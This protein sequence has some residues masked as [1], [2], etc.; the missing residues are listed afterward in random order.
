MVYSGERLTIEGVLM[1]RSRSLR[2]IASVAAVVLLMPGCD[3]ND[4]AVDT[5]LAATITTATPTTTS[6]PST[7]TAAVPLEELGPFEVT[8][9]VVSHETTRDISVWAPDADGSWPIVYLIPAAGIGQDLAEM[10][11]RLA[12]GGTVVFAPD[13]RF[14]DSPLAQE[15]DLECGYRYTRTIAHEYGGDLDQPVTVVGDSNGASL[16][17]FGGLSEATYGPGGSY[18]VCFAGAPR[19]DLIVPIAGC[20]YEYQGN[21]F[22]EPFV[23]ALVD[24]TDVKNLDADLVLVVGEDDPTCQP[25]QSEDA[26]E[27]LQAAGYN[28]RV[29]VVP[30]GDHGNMV[31]WRVVDGEWMT[32]PNDPIGKQVIQIILDAIDAAQ[33]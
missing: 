23:E 32:A 10:A 20:H 24:S 18:D 29:V 6:A 31:F 12:S 21:K 5:T 28:A 16:A 4:A 14:G 11:T 9:T 33:Q 15:Q 1:M 13:Y 25:W 3:G 8:T 7:T 30:G 22:P 17:L 2:W 27:A 26:T 19:A